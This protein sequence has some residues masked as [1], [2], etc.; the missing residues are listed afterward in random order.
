MKKYHLFICIC[1]LFL[2]SSCTRD[3]GI[4]I[5][6]LEK[7]DQMAEL[8]NVN[9]NGEYMGEY[10]PET[11]YSSGDLSSVSGICYA[12]GEPY[13]AALADGKY[14]FDIHTSKTK[15]HDDG[16]ES[17]GTVTITKSMNLETG[18]SFFL[19]P[20]P[21]CTHPGLE[22]KYTNLHALG[23]HKG[24]LYYS[25]S[26]FK[27]GTSTETI[28]KIDPAAGEFSVILEHSFHF[29]DNPRTSLFQPLTRIVGNDLFYSLSTRYEDPES[30]TLTQNYEN[31][32][33]NLETME[34]TALPEDVPAIYYVSDTYAYG[35]SEEYA[36]IVRMDDDYSNQTAIKPPEGYPNF[37]DMQVDENTGE[38]FVLMTE[39]ER[40]YG[41]LCKIV[42]DC[43]ETVSLPHETI[44]EFQL[45]RDTIYYSAY[46]PAVIGVAFRGSDMLTLDNG[47]KIYAADRMNPENSELIFSDGADFNMMDWFVLGDN[48]YLDSVMRVEE[49]GRV[50]FAP[51]RSLKH[52]RINLVNHTARYFRFE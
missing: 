18:E 14:F 38:I 51:A 35:Y 37:G 45:T 34:T 11:D 42:D 26:T 43:M 24:E 1:A 48:L 41:V 25:R 7:A 29:E 50:Y 23:Y 13:Y 21:L 6:L 47:G 27:D 36:V 44:T 49:G 22:C 16:S 10:T 3:K 32:R 39:P 2:L 5:G 33:I 4:D 9:E 31:F 20:D 17:T 52:V 30:R 12:Y 19:C 40:K 15:K 28:E 46:D 8:P